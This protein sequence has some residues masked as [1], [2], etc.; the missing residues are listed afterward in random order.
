M[1]ASKNQLA[2]LVLLTGLMI[3]TLQSCKKDEGAAP[4]S[5]IHLNGQLATLPDSTGVNNSGGEDGVKFPP[6]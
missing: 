3:V 5:K 2:G 6:H 1:K 4:R